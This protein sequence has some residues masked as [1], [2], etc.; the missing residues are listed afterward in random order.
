MAFS[1][2]RSGIMTTLAPVVGDRIR[3]VGTW[4]AYHR[5][6]AGKPS[7][8]PFSPNQCLFVTQRAFD[9]QIRIVSESFNCISVD[10]MLRDLLSGT[11]KPR[12]LAVTFD[13]GH[14]DNL[15]LGLP[16]LRKY[17]VPA[18]LFVT[19]GFVEKTLPRFWWFEHEEALRRLDLIR[20]TVDGQPRTWNTGD[21]ASKAAA[22][23]ELNT[24]FKTA[25][26][27]RQGGWLRE[28]REQAKLRGSEPLSDALTWD[29]VIALDRDPLI[30]IGAHTVSHPS[31][32]RIDKDSLR[33]EM[34][35]SKARLEEKLGHPVRHF[36]YPFGGKAHAGRREFEMARDCGF[37]SACTTR[38]GHVQKFH[39]LHPHSIPRITIDFQDTRES[40]LWKLSGLESLAKRP[41]SRFVRD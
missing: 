37:A 17:G 30:T 19:T 8:D 28:I 31:L 21:A 13:D 16:V 12:S 23:W 32:S 15:E 2:L 20:L 14:R 39:A 7:E 34:T 40:F 24:L 9:E 29:E 1:S 33:R 5:I 25:S 36:A 26:T 10:E 6:S 38:V 4:L 41:W 11:P 22:F 18:T 27:E 3:G 35:A